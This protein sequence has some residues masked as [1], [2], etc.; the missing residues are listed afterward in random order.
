MSQVKQS[1]LDDVREH[2]DESS[3][4]SVEI[5]V[6]ELSIKKGLATCNRKPLGLVEGQSQT[7]DRNTLCTLTH[8]CIKYE[9]R[10]NSARG[11]EPSGAVFDMTRSHKSATSCPSARIK[12]QENAAFSN[13]EA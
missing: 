2:R 6:E 12:T 7:D 3:A 9:N 11:E 1:N 10:E 8:L 4:L 5:S 13:L